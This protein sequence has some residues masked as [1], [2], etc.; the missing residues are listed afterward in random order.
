M[1]YYV[2]VFLLIWP[3]LR[4]GLPQRWQVARSTASRVSIAPLQPHR[5]R[6]ENVAMVSDLLAAAV[7]L[8]LC[9]RPLVG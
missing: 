1:L 9:I 8:G 4:G 6:P 5:N 3:F 2:T 7:L